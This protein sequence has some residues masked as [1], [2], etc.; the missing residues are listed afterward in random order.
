MILGI[1]DLFVTL[2]IMRFRITTLCCYTDSH[3][4]E[5]RILFTAMLNVI[6]IAKL[7]Y[8]IKMPYAECRYAECRHAVCRYVN[9]MEPSK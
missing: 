3:Y 1:S 6:F 7:G 2:S 4:A 5:C 9:V 8:N